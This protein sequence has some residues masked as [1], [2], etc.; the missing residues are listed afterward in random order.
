MSEPV[1]NSTVGGR[2]SGDPP[3]PHIEGAGG[4]PPPAAA[5]LGA[6]VAAE[7]AGIAVLAGGGGGE[8]AKAASDAAFAM[9]P[10]AATT[11]SPRWFSLGLG[12]LVV[13]LALNVAGLTGLLFW[14]RRAK[15]G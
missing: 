12:I 8:G 5:L 10:V 15:R 3:D 7:A 13:S 1:T 9:F 14:R 11:G 4:P 2:E 6:G